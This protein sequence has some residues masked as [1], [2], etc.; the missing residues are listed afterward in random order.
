MGKLQNEAF[1]LKVLINSNY[2]VSEQP[3]LYDRYMN[4]KVRIRCI[5]MRKSKIKNIFNV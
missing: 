2:S 4:L 5:E 1:Y 3:S